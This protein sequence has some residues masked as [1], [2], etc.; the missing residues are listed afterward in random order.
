MKFISAVKNTD[1]TM[2]NTDILLNPNKPY[3]D[4]IVRV[5]PTL[6]N[7][8]ELESKRGKRLGMEV[9][10]VRERIITALFMYAYGD[11]S[12]SFLPSISHE[13]DIILHNYPISIKTRLYNKKCDYGGV[14]L[15]WTV[16]WQKV[17]EFIA[18]FKPQSD[19]VYVNIV[20]GGTGAFHIIKKETQQSLYNRHG[21]AWYCKVPRQGTNY[22]GIEISREALR[23][24]AEHVDTIRIPI[25]W[26]RDRSLLEERALYR[27]W[28]ELWVSL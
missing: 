12:V 22:R 4:K 28:L 11:D 13:R 20:W 2:W 6:F 17:Q 25:Q 9:G 21:V 3:R 14:K 7:M 10:I 5:L 15:V 23:E 1:N 8:A 16:D 24:C 26:N 19:M 18:Q 27:R